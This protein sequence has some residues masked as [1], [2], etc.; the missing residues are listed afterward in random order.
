MID[1][2]Y[3]SGVRALEMCLNKQQLQNVCACKGDE[4]YTAYKIV[5]DKVMN[6]LTKKVNKF[7]TIINNHNFIGRIKIL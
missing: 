2:N 3:T 7:S 4:D 6:W 1:E 5:E